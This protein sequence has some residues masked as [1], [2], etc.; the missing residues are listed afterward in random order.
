MALTTKGKGAFRRFK[1]ELHEEHPGLLS[2]WYAFRD[3][4]LRGN[5]LCRISQT[6]SAETPASSADLIRVTSGSSGARSPSGAHHGKL[7]GVPYLRLSSWAT[8]RCAPKLRWRAEFTR[9]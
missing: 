9:G 4:R 6:A 3:A 1:D 7:R 2:A 8:S 5:A